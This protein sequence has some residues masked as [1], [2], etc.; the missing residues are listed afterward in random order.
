MTEKKPAEPAVEGGVSVTFAREWTIG[1]K[2]FKPDEDAV[3]DPGDADQVLRFGYA[4]PHDA[5]WARAYGFAGP[6]EPTGST[7]KLEG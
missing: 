3:L 6:S 2:T 4:R 1:D 7:K 5:H